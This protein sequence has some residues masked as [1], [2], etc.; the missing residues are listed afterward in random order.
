[1]DA[2]LIAQWSV[3]KRTPR[4]GDE[5]WAQYYVF[6]RTTAEQDANP[7]NFDKLWDIVYKAFKGKSKKSVDKMLGF[8]G[9]FKDRRERQY[10]FVT[11]TGWRGLEWE[12][13]DKGY[14]HFMTQKMMILLIMKEP[15]GN[16]LPSSKFWMVIENFGGL[17]RLL[18]KMKTLKS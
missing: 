8:D 11:A 5:N 7:N 10:K 14:F 18:I 2:G 13:G 12:I 9:I 3:W 16:Q 1:M 6:R 15:F 4:E 17:P